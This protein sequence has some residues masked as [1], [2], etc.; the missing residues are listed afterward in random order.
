MQNSLCKLKRLFQ[1]RNGRPG[2]TKFDRR[3]KACL[4]FFLLPQKNYN[5]ATELATVLVA[6]SRNTKDLPKILARNIE[7]NS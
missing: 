7:K 2:S 5:E 4:A 3:F 6:I 1:K